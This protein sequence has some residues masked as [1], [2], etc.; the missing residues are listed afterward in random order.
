[1]I[2][3]ATGQEEELTVALKKFLAKCSEV[4][5]FYQDF[6]RQTGLGNVGTLNDIQNLRQ[7]IENRCGF[8]Q[9]MS[10]GQE[11]LQAAFAEAMLKRVP[12][13]AGILATVPRKMEDL[14][15]AE[16]DIGKKM[17]AKGYNYIVQITTV[18][19][20]F[21]EPLYFKSADSVGPFLRSFPNYANAQIA[22]GFAM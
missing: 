17:K 4:Y 6:L 14:G 13:S 10:L 7:F 9:R 12:V 20:S 11:A 2:L 22:W 21:G 8:F 1:M 3:R 15:A 5:K 18:D 19:G 16:Q